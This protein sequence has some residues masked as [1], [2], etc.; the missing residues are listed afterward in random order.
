MRAGRKWGILLIVFPFLNT[1][2][3]VKNAAKH[4]FTRLP[5]SFHSLKRS[6][7]DFQLT[8]PIVLRGTGWETDL[9]S[10]GMMLSRLACYI[11][12]SRLTERLLGDTLDFA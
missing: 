6:S 1:G 4:F 12:S 3:R 5:V 8:L 7:T 9:H 10:H 11:S 2:S